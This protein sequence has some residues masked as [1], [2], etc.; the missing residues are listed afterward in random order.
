MDAE[1]ATLKLIGLAYEAALEPTRWREFLRQVAEGVG[2][3]SAF[4]RLVDCEAS[5][6]ALF[7]NFGYDPAYTAAYRDHFVR[8][9]PYA[10]RWTK[11]PEG[12]IMFS[13]EVD[14]Q[15]RRKSEYHNEYE[16]PQGLRQGVGCVL[17]RN[18]SYDLQFA[19]QRG[20]QHQMFS[21]DG[22][23]MAMLSTLVPHL[24]RAVQVHERLSDA[25]ALKTWALEALH[26][27][28]TGV[29]LIDNRGRH[30]FCNQAAEQMINAYPGMGLTKDGITFPRAADANQLHKLV[31]N[32]G[33]VAR[34]EYAAAN[35][36]MQVSSANGDTLQIQVA[37]LLGEK[38]PWGCT[39]PH[40]TL[41]LF[42][43]RPGGQRLPW[44]S[45]VAMH[46]LTRAE[47]KLAAKLAEGLSLED[48]AE[49]LTI[50]I[51]TARSQLKAIF[52]K[53]GV[54]R[55]SELVTLLLTGVLAH[56][57]DKQQGESE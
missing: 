11:A 25:F 6:V 28:R 20:P 18:D 12:T 44:E 27:L 3:R 16:R 21:D 5:K 43:S 41:A 45:L 7:E 13:E 40:G 30:F 15:A 36:C 17:M 39:F 31:C 46:G 51:E 32:A 23:A 38:T 47:A 56:C 10:D 26:Q 34:G 42:I 35:G 22:N 14:W 37:P 4:L 50:S 29:M 8:I 1:N 52:H 24:K 2:A 49:K 19:L 48:T 53:T 9:D 57:A 54:R 33:R 55:Q